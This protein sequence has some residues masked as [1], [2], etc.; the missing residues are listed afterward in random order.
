[1]TRYDADDLDP[2]SIKELLQQKKRSARSIQEK[3]RKS[4]IHMKKQADKSRRHLEF[5][6]GDLV[7]V[8]LQLYKQQSL[9]LTNNPKLTM[10]YFGPFE[11]VERIGTV[12]YKLKLF[13]IVMIHPVFHVSALKP[14]KGDVSQP[15]MPFSMLTNEK[16]SL[17]QPIKVMN[18]W[19]ILENR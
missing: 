17:L 11:T 6:V 14:F 13:S 12:T 1:L 3:I 16:D 9:A 4:A 8:K 5:V 18:C 19:M 2:P 15:Y 7:L 10:I